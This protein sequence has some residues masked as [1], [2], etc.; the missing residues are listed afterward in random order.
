M[1]PD[2]YEVYRDEEGNAKA[3]MK[4]S[5]MFLRRILKQY[6]RWLIVL[7]VV[8]GVNLQH[9]EGCFQMH[10]VQHTTSYPPEPATNSTNHVE[11]LIAYISKANDRMFDKFYRKIGAINFSLSNSIASL[12]KSMEEL[13]LKV[14]YAHETI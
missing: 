11:D 4:G 13:T 8:I 7:K 3:R 2:E 6:L 9:Y 12:S 14:D 1:S 5:S 10:G